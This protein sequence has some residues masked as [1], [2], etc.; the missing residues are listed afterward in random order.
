MSRLHLEKT[1]GGLVLDT[2]EGLKK[3]GASGPVVIP[4]SRHKAYYSR[5]FVITIC[6]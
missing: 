6:A 1:D 3:G 2:K 5:R 4:E